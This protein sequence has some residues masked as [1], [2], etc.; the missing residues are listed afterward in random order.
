MAAADDPDVDD[1]FQR[2]Q[3]LGGDGFAV[4]AVDERPE[5]VL[6]LPLDIADQM[7]QFLAGRHA[8]QSVPYRQELQT[9]N[10]EVAVVEPPHNRQLLLQ[11]LDADRPG[12][13]LQM[14][15]DCERL[16]FRI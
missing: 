3:L 8:L 9:I 11:A 10:A 6:E 15:L 7:A 1:K 4:A 14:T 16:S 13:T 5:E 12:L 2:A